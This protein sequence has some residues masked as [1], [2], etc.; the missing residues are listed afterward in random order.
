MLLKK[1]G[2]STIYIGGIGGSKKLRYFN[3]IARLASFASRGHIRLYPS[4]V[5]VARIND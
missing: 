4:I 2:F 1:G 3:L 5:A